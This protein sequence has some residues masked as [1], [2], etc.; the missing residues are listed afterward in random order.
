M[1]LGQK[2]LKKVIHLKHHQ[3][4]FRVITVIHYSMREEQTHAWLQVSSLKF[5]QSLGGQTCESLGDSHP[6]CI[7]LVQWHSQVTGIGWAPAVAVY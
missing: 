7:S 1:L 5:M 6:M 4:K 2:S 3:L